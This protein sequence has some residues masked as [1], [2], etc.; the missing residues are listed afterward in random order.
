MSPRED[1]FNK[2]AK[3]TG[4]SGSFGRVAEKDQRA[5]GYIT[6]EWYISD[7]NENTLRGKENTERQ[8][9][10]CDDQ[11]SMKPEMR[12]RPMMP[13]LTLTLLMT[14]PLVGVSIMFMPEVGFGLA[15]TFIT[16]Y[17]YVSATSAAGLL[18][19]KHLRSGSHS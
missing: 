1:T 16:L 6:R 10:E 14:P 12:T 19:L 13:M 8:F 17:W 15:A 3:R 7:D 4:L 18:R 11:A 2:K 5:M 9:S